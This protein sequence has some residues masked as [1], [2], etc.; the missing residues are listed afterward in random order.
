MV[1]FL[2][3][4]DVEGYQYHS[5]NAYR[6]V[7]MHT[8]VDGASVGQHPQV[9]R[10]LKGAYRTRPPLPRYSSTWDVSVVL[11]FLEGYVVH[12]SMQLKLLTLRMVMLLAPSRPSR[13]A[14]LVKLDLR[15]YYCYPEGACFIPVSL[16]IMAR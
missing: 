12:E 15:G 9:S 1:N 14:D 16:A 11:S 4:L 2:A 6:S 8:H 10:L 3:H 5:L 13:S 7:S